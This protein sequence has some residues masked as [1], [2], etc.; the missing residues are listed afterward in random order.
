M[1]IKELINTVESQK[2]TLR[3]LNGYSVFKY[4]RALLEDIDEQPIVVEIPQ[5]IEDWIIKSRDIYTVTQAMTFG[6]SKVNN[7]LNEKDNQ[8]KFIL[9]WYYDYKV[10]D[11]KYLVKI[12]NILDDHSFLNYRKS[13]GTCFFKDEHETENIRT[14]H[15]RDQLEEIGFGEVFDNP[16]FEVRK[17]Q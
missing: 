2:E 13:T 14:Y 4:I 16:L 3:Q 12:K 7:W 15:T 10:Y 5:F 1:N 11:D 8:R 9:A 17:I 6:G